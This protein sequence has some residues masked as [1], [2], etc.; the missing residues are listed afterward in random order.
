MKIYEAHRQNKLMEEIGTA[1]RA[2]SKETKKEV[3]KEP[4]VTEPEGKSS[5]ESKLKTS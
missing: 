3:K 4:A 5:T 1:I 2:K